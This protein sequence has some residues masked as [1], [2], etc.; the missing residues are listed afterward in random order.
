[1]EP[2]YLIFIKTATGFFILIKPGGLTKTKYSKKGLKRSEIALSQKRPAFGTSFALLARPVEKWFFNFPPLRLLGCTTFRIVPPSPEKEPFMN[3]TLSRF[4]ALA[5]VSAVLSFGF[6]QTSKAGVVLQND[7]STVASANNTISS[8]AFFAS[9]F[10]T[11]SSGDLDFVSASFVFGAAVPVTPIVE[12]YTAS[13]DTPNTLVTALSGSAVT[14]A[15]AAAYTF[16][17]TA[18]LTPSTSYYLTVAAPV[19]AD[20]QWYFADAPPAEAN[21]SGWVFK[22]AIRTTDSGSSW[23][24]NSLAD[25]STVRIE[26]V[27]EPSAFV[28]TAGALALGCVAAARR[29]RA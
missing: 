21:T 4:A 14:G 29:R 16:T 2:A 7:F 9:G 5:V 17:G 18:S 13:G 6:G 26:A 11:P 10:T 15:S 3:A 27:P 19:G 12:L 8:S 28:I 24:T 23:S 20:F 1:M 22:N 25:F